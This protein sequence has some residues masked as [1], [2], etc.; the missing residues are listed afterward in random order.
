MFNLAA[1]EITA[2]FGVMMKL[3]FPHRFEN[4]S[5][6]LYLGMGWMV[7]MV[8]KPLA[9]SMAPADFWL[10]I[11]G[12]LIYSL[13]VIFYVWDRMPYHKVIWHGFVLTAAMLQFSAVAAEFAR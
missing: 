10:L 13:G 2:S 4:L 11:A 7:V 9:A 5:I 8:L 12:G 6:A 3:L 1:P